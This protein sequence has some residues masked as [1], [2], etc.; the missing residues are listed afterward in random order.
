MVE[1]HLAPTA[2]SCTQHALGLRVRAGGTKSYIVQ[3]RNSEGRTRRL[4]VGVR[5]RLTPDAARERFLSYSE[6]SRL[7]E[8]QRDPGRPTRGRISSL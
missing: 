8:V 2:L 3:Y 1:S 5:G 7:G 4:T 6:F